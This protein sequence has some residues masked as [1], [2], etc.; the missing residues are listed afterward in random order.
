VRYYFLG[1]GLLLCVGIFSCTSKKVYAPLPKSPSKPYQVY[2]KTYTPLPSANNYVEEGIASWYGPKF[3]GRRTASG[4][5]YNMYAYTAAHK[6]LPF[7]TKVRVTNLDNG[8][9]V[10][11]K[12]N[13]RG[14]FVAGRIIDLSYQAAR[15]LGMVGPGTARVRVESLHS[16]PKSKIKGTFYIQVGSFSI[17]Q[18]ALKLQHRLS[19]LGYTSRLVQARKNGLILWRVQVGP[20]YNL[21]QAETNKTKL[22]DIFKGSFIF[23]N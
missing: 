7:H 8:K 5:I 3:H 6:V 22:S 16:L 4:E 9:Q 18:N 14:P 13:D 1:L 20:Y 11:V 19:L 12:I 23:M 10:I 17:K 15:A 2:G 21:L